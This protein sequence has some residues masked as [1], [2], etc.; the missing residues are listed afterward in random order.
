MTISKTALKKNCLQQGLQNGR[1]HPSVTHSDQNSA[2]Q[3]QEPNH[4]QQN[5]H[6]IF[7]DY[8]AV[9]ISTTFAT[10]LTYSK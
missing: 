8:H 6:L 2:Q 7:A 9:V 10:I 4:N 3:L 1:H 5:Y